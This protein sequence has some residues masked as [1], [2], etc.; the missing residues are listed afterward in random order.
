MIKVDPKYWTQTSSGNVF[1]LGDLDANVYSLPDIATSLAKQCRYNGN[2]RYFYSVA[3]H[4]YLASIMAPAEYALETLMHDASEAYIGDIIRP[5]KHGI[6]G[7][8]EL[9]DQLHASIFKHFGLIWPMPDIVHEID[10]RM[11]RTEMALLMPHCDPVEWGF[12]NVQPYDHLLT[13][14]TDC[15]NWERSEAMF[16]HRFNELTKLRKIAA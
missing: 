2:C 6:P 11:L 10:N 5:I 1:R 13:R 14:A 16:T 9:E 4:S 7:L 12:G 3:Q 15:W 8:C